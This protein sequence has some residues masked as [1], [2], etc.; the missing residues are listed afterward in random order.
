MSN[1]K[2]GLFGKLFSNIGSSV[3]DIDLNRYTDLED[4]YG[5]IGFIDK[6]GGFYRVRK[7]GSMDCGHGEWAY[8]FLDS[9][10][11]KLGIQPSL[12]LYKNIHALLEDPRLEMAFLYEISDSSMGEYSQIDYDSSV[13]EIDMS[14]KQ[15]EVIKNLIEHQNKK[16]QS[17]HN[18]VRTM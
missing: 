4:M 14:L 15:K 2:K 13:G 1:S 16:E 5:Y 8:Y 10:K 12:K 6:D 3:P 9:M 18:N 7:I 11:D 17:F